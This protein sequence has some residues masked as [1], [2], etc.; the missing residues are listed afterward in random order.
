LTFTQNE[1]PKVSKSLKRCAFARAI[2]AHEHVLGPELKLE[3]HQT[4]K[5]IGKESRQHGKSIVISIQFQT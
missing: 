3:V 5:I 1:P 2:V 4:A